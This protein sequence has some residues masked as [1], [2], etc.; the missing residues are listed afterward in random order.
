MKTKFTTIDYYKWKAP[1]LESVSHSK[2]VL[3]IS[4]YGFMRSYCQQYIK[5]TKVQR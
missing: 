3:S 4:F 5:S 2:H 1:T